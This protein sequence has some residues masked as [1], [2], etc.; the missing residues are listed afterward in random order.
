MFVVFSGVSG[1]LLDFLKSDEGF[2]L[3]LPKL[4]DFSAQVIL[5]L[6]TI[7]LIFKKKKIKK[8]AKLIP[9]VH[10]VVKQ[11]LHYYFHC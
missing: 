1:S 6:T 2:K 9:T 7:G 4:I 11:T 8:K 3:Q 5:T 10:M